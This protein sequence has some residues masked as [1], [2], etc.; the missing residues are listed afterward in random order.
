[1]A[2]ENDNGA[3]EPWNVDRAVYEAS[4]PTPALALLCAMLKALEA[5][6]AQEGKT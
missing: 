3:E 1:M 6:I 4:G 2:D 5:L